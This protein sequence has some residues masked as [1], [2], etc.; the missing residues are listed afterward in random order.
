LP[1][2]STF[3]PTS[4]NAYNKASVNTSRPVSPADL[5]DGQGLCAGAAAA[6]TVA[7][8]G[9]P[10]ETR[11]TRGVGLDMTECE[12]VRIL[13]QPQS[14]NVGS[15]ERGERSVVMTYTMTE[16]AGIYR[17]VGG[18]LVSIERGA[19]PPPVATPEKKP[20]KKQAKRPA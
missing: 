1:S 13:G 16:R 11:I 10:S 6:E 19:E 7:E 12:V 15:D 14:A 8:S 2:S 5:V 9:G 20:A 18:R 17:F 4:A 3:I